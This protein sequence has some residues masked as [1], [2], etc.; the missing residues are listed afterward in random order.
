VTSGSIID[1]LSKRGILVSLGVHGRKLLWAK[2]GNRCSY[3]YEGEVCDEE[4][5]TSDGGK[6]TLVG[7]ECHIVGE[8]PTAARYIADFHGRNTYDNLI[9]L[10]R[11]H[12]K[13]IDDNE[14][15]YTIA[16][17]QSMKRSHEESVVKRTEQKEI[18]PI[19]IKD[20]VFRTEVKHADEAIG[21]EVNRPAILSNVRSE[22]KAGDVKRAVGFS[23]NQPL[24]V[25]MMTCSNCRRLL[26]FVCTGPHPP[27]VTCPHCGKV[28]ILH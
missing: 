11:K 7:E 22:L 16:V 18:Q 24:N 23:T 8:K 26:P 27:T 10:C 19:V 2:A 9:L 1:T 28:N 12:H 3:R 17:L 6:I 4:L 25:T 20:S 5:V 15:K 14:E 21:M 13:I